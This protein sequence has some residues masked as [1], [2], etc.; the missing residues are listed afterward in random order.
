MKEIF[1]EICRL[2]TPYLNTRKNDIHT[3]I[4][5]E[6]ALILLDKEGGEEDIVIPAIILHDTGWKKIPEELHLM[7]FGP[8]MTLPELNRIHEVESVRIAKK[9]PEKLNYDK[10]KTD[11]ILT[12]IDGH[13]SRSEA[14]SLNDRIVK[15]ADK[16]WRYSKTGFYIDIERFGETFE[17]AIDRLNSNAEKYFF[18]NSSKEMARDE[19]KIRIREL[20]HD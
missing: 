16:L 15:D 7:A 4:C 11:E 5:T 12:I 20:D 6:F 9:I 10:N 1:N 13:D 2:A 18:T 3:D 19:I 8:R 14:I 17:G